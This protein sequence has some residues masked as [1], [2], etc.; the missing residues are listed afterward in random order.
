MRRAAACCILRPPPRTVRPANVPPDV[1]FPRAPIPGMN[2]VVHLRRD[3]H[4]QHEIRPE[5]DP[6][7]EPFLR[8]LANLIARQVLHEFE[9]EHTNGRNHDEG[10]TLYPQVDRRLR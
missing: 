3:R 8:A 5:I 9:E 4:N 10:R 1:A 7:L 2:P 6:R